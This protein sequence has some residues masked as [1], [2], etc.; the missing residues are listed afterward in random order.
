MCVYIY[1]YIYTYIYIYIYT[2]SEELGL[3][4]EHV[5]ILAKDTHVAIAQSDT[6]IVITNSN[7]SNT[8]TNVNNDR[9]QVTREREV[10]SWKRPSTPPML[11]HW[12]VR[13]RTSFRMRTWLSLTLNTFHREPFQ[14]QRSTCTCD[15]RWPEQACFSCSQFPK[16]QSEKV[17]PHF[18]A[19][20]FQRML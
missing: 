2:C 15:G 5:R 3:S 16:V 13:Q 20:S 17:H 7:A 14:T 4:E 19:S 8:N 12:D 11:E 10:S 18:G 1:I 6:R 9:G